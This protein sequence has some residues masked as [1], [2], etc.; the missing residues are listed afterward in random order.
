LS[1]KVIVRETSVT[2]T[3]HATAVQPPSPNQ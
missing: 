3:L 1:G 2:P